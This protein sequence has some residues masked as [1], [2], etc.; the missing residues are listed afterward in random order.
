MSGSQLVFNAR[1]AHTLLDA[2]HNVTLIRMQPFKYRDMTA[3]IDPRVDQWIVEA[4]S[5]KFDYDDIQ[6]A[7]AAMAFKSISLFELLKAENRKKMSLFTDIFLDTCEAVLNDTAFMQR[8][9]STPF[10]IAFA[11][12]YDYCGVGL[13]HAAKIPTWIWLDS[14]PMWDYMA[15]EIGAPLP[16]SYVPPLM[17]DASDQMSFVQRLKSFLGFFIIPYLHQGIIAP[18]ETAAFRR[19]IDPNFPDLRELAR[20]APL[21]MVNSDEL[22]DLAQPTLHKAI[23]IGGLGVR[24]TQAN[25]LPTEFAK[26]VDAAN[27]V[28]VVS[29]GSIVNASMMP[30]ELKVAFMKAFGRFPKT[31][32]FFRYPLDD[33]VDIKPANVMT[34]KWLPQADL[35]QH[36]KARALLAH[37]GYNSLQEA[38]NS[39]IPIIT[40]PLFGD[41]W[42][43]ARFAEGRGFGYYLDKADLNKHSIAKAIEAVLT[44]DGYTREIRKLQRLVEAKPHKAEENLVK[45]T[46]FL[47]EFRDLSN[48]TPYGVHLSFIE[49]Y[50]LDVIAFLLAVLTFAVIVIFLFLRLIVRKTCSLLARLMPRSDKQKSA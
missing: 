10:D 2:G 30:L 8:L 38:I 27:S 14:A 35:L 34:S 16:P 37:G 43:N 1:V 20:N 49:Y 44:D 26:L 46:E 11:H 17:M 15:R 9:R 24:K 18:I 6:R 32:F 25:P 41:Q 3:K 42:R 50:S 48:L 29:F 39:G 31:Q 28:V 4:L 45:W 7:N 36:P 21:V 22:Y 19:I 23:N 12:M 47:A 33:L 5:P 13:V 40:I